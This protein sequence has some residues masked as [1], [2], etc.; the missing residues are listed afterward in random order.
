MVDL[1]KMEGLRELQRALEQLPKRV[2]RRILNASLMAGGRIIAKD[3]E[4]RAPVLQQ[5]DPRRKPGTL[6]ANVRA[7]LVRPQD[8]HAATAIVYVR[9]LDAETVRKFKTQQPRGAQ[10][11]ANNPDDP[12]YWRW[13][14]LG[15]SKM[16]PQ[17]FLRPA[18]EAQKYA[19]ADS[20]KG[21][22]AKRVE[23]EADKLGKQR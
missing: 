15:T 16:R 12:F 6:R 1:V 4:V 21:R 9:K 3:A 18:F 19:A 5:P 10:K 13:V 17:P 23:I 14:E 8:G 2:T 11:G 20:I 7:R 22:I